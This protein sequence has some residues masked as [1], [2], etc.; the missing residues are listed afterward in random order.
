MRALLAGRYRW[1]RAAAGSYGNRPDLA[2]AFLE[3]SLEL[4][5]PGGI[6]AMLVPAKIATAGYGATARH[7]LASTTTLH[8]IAN[9]T[10]QV[11]ADFDA[12]VYPMALIAGKAAPPPEHR[13]R[14]TL[15]SDGNVG[16]RQSSLAGGG[17]WILVKDRLRGVLEALQ[18]D[19]PALGE[20]FVCHLGLKTG[21]NHVF[22]NPPEEV[23]PEVLRWAVRGRDI[24]TFRCS[25]KTRLL[26][27][28]DAE[29]WPRSELPPRCTAYLAIHQRELRARRDYA[30]G[31]PWAVFRVRPAIA[32]Y[33]VIWADLAKELVA[34]ALTT[35]SDRSQIPLNSC[36]VTTTGSA[37]EAERLTACLNSTWLRA[38]A[39][40][41]AVPAASGF[42]R[43]NAGTI[44]RLPLPSSAFTDSTFSRVAQQG[45][46]GA[47]VQGEL[48]DAMAVHLGLSD[49]AQNALRTV[50]AGA[51]HRR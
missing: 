44:A 17:P 8:T 3:R 32:K 24:A 47:Q 33:R 39:R 25:R 41:G 38:V 37:V 22:L 31:P 23:E 28:H 9:L 21:A 19:H 42:A 13:V 36:Y 16:V 2:V 27:T 12:T 34:A 29:G 43:F 6:V 51:R 35:G 4:A 7:A 18:S 48:D 20:R 5:A 26:W 46:A 49:N 10:E 1:W 30:G 15:A 40:L 45:R 50:V 11:G 14:A